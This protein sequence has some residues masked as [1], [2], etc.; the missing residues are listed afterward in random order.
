[1][2]YSV[3]GKCKC[4]MQSL[5]NSEKCCLLRGVESGARYRGPGWLPLVCRYDSR[6]LT[7]QWG[8]FVCGV[9]LMT[10]VFCR[11]CL[12]DRNVKLKDAADF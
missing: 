11:E 1:M 8:L 4:D 3:A 9:S 6:A 7:G 2:L 10:G 5:R 12:Y